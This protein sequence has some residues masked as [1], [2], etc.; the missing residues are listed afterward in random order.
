VINYSTSRHP[1]LIK[2]VNRQLVTGQAP[3]MSS[4]ACG[5]HVSLITI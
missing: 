2:F 4:L 1:C 3:L 5:L